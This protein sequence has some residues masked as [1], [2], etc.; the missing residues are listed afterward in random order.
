VS[1]H[2]FRDNHQL[3]VYRASVHD[4][5]Q[6]L[7]LLEES[8]RSF[9]AFGPEDLPQLLASGAC[10]IAPD[11]DTVGAFLCVSVNRARWAFVRG[12]AIKNGWRTDEGLRAVLESA[13]DRLRA[14]GVTHLAV[15]GTALWLPP[16][17]LRAGFERWEWIV[18]LERHPRPLADLTAGP[19]RVRPVQPDDLSRLAALDAAIFES[20]Y[21]LASGEL[22]ELMVTS[23]HFVLAESTEEAGQPALLGYACADVLG[24]TGQIIRL[25]VHPNAQRQGIGR[26]LL[27]HGLAYC[28]A[29]GARQ[30]T[31][32]TQESNAASLRLYEQ[33]GF[34]R[35][36]RRVPLL[37]RPLGSGL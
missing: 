18:S 16:A 5:P 31:I 3:Q 6:V 10:T 2:S 13:I 25:A 35:V 22:I 36:G 12:V 9:A 8:R 29:N 4:Q 19:A 21:Q 14:E 28:H 15:Y 37:V 23:G 11:G 33:I 24:D 7:R 17:L 20:P 1:T 26:A 34:R 32:N 30:V 27:N